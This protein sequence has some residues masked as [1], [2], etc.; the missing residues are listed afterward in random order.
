MSISLRFQPLFR[1][2]SEQMPQPSLLH[3]TSVTSLTHYYIISQCIASHLRNMQKPPSN[4]NTAN[5]VSPCGY[6]LKTQERTTIFRNI[7][8]MNVKPSHFSRSR[9]VNRFHAKNLP[10]VLLDERG[11]E[12]NSVQN[13]KEDQICRSLPC[14]DGTCEAHQP[15]LIQIF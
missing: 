10:R 6:L 8:V 9:M 7:Y 1:C 14:S 2:M 12:P 5:L 15:T 13:G 3:I 4:L 11:F